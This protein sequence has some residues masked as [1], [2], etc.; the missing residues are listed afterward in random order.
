MNMFERSFERFFEQKKVLFKKKI[1][2]KKNLNVQKTVHFFFEQ[3][4]FCTKLLI[5]LEKFTKFSNEQMFN[6]QCS[7][8]S[9]N[10][11]KENYSLFKIKFERSM[12]VFE[13]SFEQKKI[14][15]K[16]KVCSKKNLNVH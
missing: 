9:M 14:F 13:R 15:K 8:C 16:K 10:K 1:C 2:S 12:N 3:N 4:F 7:K 5:T 11:K 6:E